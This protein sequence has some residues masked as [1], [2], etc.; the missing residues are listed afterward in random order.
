MAIID[1]IKLYPLRVLKSLSLY[2]S[3]MA[4]GLNLG[5][6]GPTLLDLQILAQ[7]SFS[8]ISYIMPGRAGGFTI[9]SLLGKMLYFPTDI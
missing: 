6:P 3:M 5:M 9:G 7:S 1:Q 4:I 2:L 8:E